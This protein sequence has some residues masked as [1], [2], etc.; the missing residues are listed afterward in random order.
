MPTAPHL[1]LCRMQIFQLLISYKYPQFLSNAGIT[2]TVRHSGSGQ[3]SSNGGKSNGSNCITIT[4]LLL[5]SD[6]VNIQYIS[7]CL[8]LDVIGNDISTLRCGFIIWEIK[9]LGNTIFK[10]KCIYSIY[11]VYYLTFYRIANVC[12]L[13]VCYTL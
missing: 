1:P 3:S 11:N 7:M 13:I 4:V 10:R 6:K 5:F 12:F 9:C 2:G 8:L